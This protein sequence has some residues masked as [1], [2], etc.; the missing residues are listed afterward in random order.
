MSNAFVN[1]LFLIS[2]LPLPLIMMA[3]AMSMRRMP[4][5]YGESTGY[6]TK[7]SRKSQETWDY[8]Q[9]A[10]GRCA[11]K[12]FALTSAGTFA[13]WLITFL[14]DLD[15]KQGFVAFMV[16]T[17]VQVA[18]LFGVIMTVERQLNEKFDENG[19]PRGG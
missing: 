10:Y 7:R 18:V 5:K 15:D 3:F 6:N 19:K 13:V 8:A 2:E 17:A 12:A 4:P 11:T 14:L 16:I 9:T 1:V